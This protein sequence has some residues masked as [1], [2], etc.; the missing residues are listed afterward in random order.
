VRS[1]ETGFGALRAMHGLRFPR[2]AVS[3]GGS[4]SSWDR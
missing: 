4:A 2:Q 1:Q 3:A